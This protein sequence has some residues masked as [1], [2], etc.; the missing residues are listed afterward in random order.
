MDMRRSRF[1]GK[2]ETQYV[3]TGLRFTSITTVVLC[4]CSSYNSSQ[5]SVST[6]RHVA[7]KT[8]EASKSDQD[9]M[10]GMNTFRLCFCNASFVTVKYVCA[11]GHRTIFSY[12]NN[13]TCVNANRQLVPNTTYPTPILPF[14][15]VTR[16]C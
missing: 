13:S 3:S 15:I 10:V 6:E 7:Y 2:C 8:P 12:L 1:H 4:Y 9:T 5:V 14:T 11:R 16:D